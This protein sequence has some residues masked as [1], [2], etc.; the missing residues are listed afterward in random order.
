MAG[1]P[2]ALAR[3][4]HPGRQRAD[5]LAR[6]GLC[7]SRDLPALES[8]AAG[9]QRHRVARLRCVALGGRETAESPAR[10]TVRAPGGSGPAPFTC[11]RAEHDGSRGA[12]GR[13][14]PPPYLRSR[15]AC[16]E[17]REAVTPPPFLRPRRACR[18]LVSSP[19]ASVW[20]RF[21]SF[22]G[23]NAPEVQSHVCRPQPVRR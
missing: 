15:R 12:G 22:W 4:G 5:A 3:T 23:V 17:P 16:W 11:D 19:L 14:I 9:L 1:R 7:G 18:E 10:P 8:V 20:T 6:S 2:R 21:R 13:V